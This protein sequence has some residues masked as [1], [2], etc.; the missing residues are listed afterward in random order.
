MRK[1]NQGFPETRRTKHH[2]P[3]RENTTQRDFCMPSGVRRPGESG[4]ALRLNRE[5]YAAQ[6]VGAVSRIKVSVFAWNLRNIK[7]AAPLAPLRDSKAAAHTSKTCFS[8]GGKSLRQRI[9]RQF[10]HLPAT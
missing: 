2:E 6:L 7:E 10:R 3:E 8:P 9:K 4:R 1:I 5:I